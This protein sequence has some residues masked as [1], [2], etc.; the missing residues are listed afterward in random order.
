[1]PIKGSPPHWSIEAFELYLTSKPNMSYKA[2]FAQYYDLFYSNKDYQFECEF[3]HSEIRKHVKKAPAD[4]SI[5]EL[6]C[7][8]GTHAAWI[9]Q[10]GY[11]IIATDRSN[12]MLEIARNKT[13]QFQNAKVVQMD[14]QN[15][16]EFDKKFDVVLCLFDSIGYLISN[17]SIT[18]AFH[19]IQSVMSENG[20][21][22]MEFWN[23]GTM[24]KSFDPYRE[25]IFEIGKTSV[26]R[27]S[28][29]N[30]DY[31]H[32]TAIVNFDVLEQTENSDHYKLVWHETHENRFFMIQEMNS[33]L[34]HGGLKALDYFDGFSEA[35]ADQNSWH[36]VS[37]CQKA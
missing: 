25:K 36:V 1:V 19:N 10:K 34:K 37:V 35:R 9:A 18:S 26:K 17:D 30:L 22:I 16:L 2:S 5:L 12:D 11:Q 7:G 33:L 6:A 32:Q 4:V 3:L 20:I 15:F 13:A 28:K 31:Y 29:T 23:A 8:T 27:I 24:L 21:F 14:M